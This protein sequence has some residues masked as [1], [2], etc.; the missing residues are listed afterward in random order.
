MES[1]NSTKE[2]PN[3]NQHKHIKHNLKHI[4]FPHTI[5]YGYICDFNINILVFD[6]AVID[7]LLI[8]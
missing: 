4:H 5:Y 6:H 2:V 8:E 3:S 1:T 7:H